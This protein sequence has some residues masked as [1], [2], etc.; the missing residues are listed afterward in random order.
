MSSTRHI[1]CGEAAASVRTGTP[2]QVLLPLVRDGGPVNLKSDD[3][4]KA[5]L[6][7]LPQRFEDLV[8]IAAYVY[9]GDQAVLRG[10]DH[11]DRNGGD[12]RRRF[13]FRIPVRDVD[14]W[15]SDK[16]RGKLVDVLGFLSED[17][18]EFEFIPMRR[19]PAGQGFLQFT[20]KACDGKIPDEVAMFSGGL[21]SLAGAVVRQAVDR[22][23]LL[24][25][26]HR[27]H[28]K[29]GKTDSILRGELRKR[30]GGFGP[31]QVTVHVNKRVDFGREY[32]QR[33]RSFLFTAIGGTVATMLGQNALTFFENGIISLNLPISGQVIGA[34]ATRTTHPKTLRGFREL[35]TMLCEADFRVTNPFLWDTKADVVRKIVE[36]GYGELIR[37]SR[38]CSH[39]K[40]STRQHPHC[41]VCSQCVDRRFAMYAA[42]ADQL[43]AAADYRVDLFTG[44]RPKEADRMLVSHYVLNAERFKDLTERELM[45]R[46]GEVNRALPHMEGG[47]EAN[48]AR[49]MDLLH[50]HGTQVVEVVDKAIGRHASEMRLGT[51][52]A[53]CLISLV[54]DRKAL[55]GPA[56]GPGIDS[57]QPPPPPR[58]PPVDP[59]NFLIRLGDEAW[60]FRFGGGKPDFIFNQEGAAIL[61]YLLTH[62]NQSFDVG[63]VWKA[64]GLDRQGPNAA[65]ALAKGKDDSL[66]ETGQLEGHQTIADKRY[67]G[68]VYEELRE[69]DEEIAEAR[70]NNDSGRLEAAETKR[71]NLCAHVGKLMT[72]GKRLRAFA[73]SRKKRIDATRRSMQRLLAHIRKKHPAFADHLS[74]VVLKIGAKLEYHPAAP[75]EW[76]TSV[77]LLNEG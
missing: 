14:F 30:G 40:E 11:P 3:I 31:V 33:T 23:R 75:I 76:V 71:E 8:E 55:P 20:E 5:V 24:L 29:F 70:R 46:Y 7:D 39:P 50:R 13:A 36:N 59:E 56:A 22:K 51:L 18:Y 16:V 27:S 72:P 60:R 48:A 34:R 68:E 26:T 61:E 52:P 62:P 73:T 10:K 12:W 4:Q 19:L 38:S 32:T 49:V 28:H 77:R 1:L 9:C 25:V 37:P 66:T 74:P 63:D 64:V 69:L 35:M 21:D 54:V 41:G 43:D 47:A 42:G 53:T 67:I 65:E 44:A 45:S 57:P 58:Q 15:R 17:D 6:R 2:D